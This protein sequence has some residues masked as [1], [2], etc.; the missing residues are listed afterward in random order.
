MNSD[1]EKLVTTEKITSQKLL[2]VMVPP[3]LIWGLIVRLLIINNKKIHS[4][5]DSRRGGLINILLM[6]N[7]LRAN[8]S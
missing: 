1:K 3:S 2:S 4:Q 8:V 5:Y 7:Y 6:K